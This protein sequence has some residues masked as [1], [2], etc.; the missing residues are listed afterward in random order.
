MDSDRQLF[1]LAVLMFGVSA[2]YSVFLWRKGFRRDDHINYALLLAAFGLHTASMFER[3]FRLDRCPVTNL[4][5]ATLFAMWA[6]LAVYLVVGLWP[7]LR[8]LGAF[9]APVLLGMGVF[10][11]MPHL[12]VRLT[13][14][15]DL[16]TVWTS[17]H[18][19]LIALAYGAFGLSA[20]AAMMYLSQEHNLK[21]HK[22]K[23]IF[24]FMPSI[25]RL[26][27]VSNRLLVA[28]FALLTIGL[29]IGAYA[30]SLL[31]NAHS[32][33]GDPK[34]VWS[35]IVWLVYLGLIIARWRFAQGGRRFAFGTVLTFAFVLL[36][37][38]GTNIF[39]TLHNPP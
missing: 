33:R 37:F 12:D 38:W 26:E 36:T 24:S 34:I 4:Y 5:E 22:L 3:G 35:A 11:F 15:T 14:R 19:A 6:L 23:A 27:R 16:P 39:S 9:A 29:V 30:L 25:Q 28:G 1:L 21:L 13:A 2:L 8:F 18:A 32:Y 17:V 20:V 31:P 7:R 10:A